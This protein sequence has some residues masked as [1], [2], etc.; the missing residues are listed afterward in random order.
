MA[1]QWENG[2]TRLLQ[3]HSGSL[4]WIHGYLLQGSVLSP[5]EFTLIPFPF[6]SSGNS[7]QQLQ[8]LVYCDQ[9]RSQKTGLVIPNDQKG[10]SSRRAEGERAYREYQKCSVVKY[11]VSNRIS[12]LFNS[13]RKLLVHG[14]HMVSICAFHVRREVSCGGGRIRLSNGARIFGTELH[15]ALLH[16]RTEILL[17]FY[18]CV[19]ILQQLHNQVLTLS[20]EPHLFLYG[21]QNV[22][23]VG[24]DDWLIQ[25]SSGLSNHGSPEIVA[26]SI[27][28]YS[29][30]HRCSRVK[31]LE[32]DDLD[33]NPGAAAYQL[34]D[35]GL[36][37]KFLCSP[38]Y[39]FVKL[40]Q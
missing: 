23:S 39:L 13:F 19:D 12:L 36:I 18:L 15:E 5:R 27:S 1:G 30:R 21:D 29:R 6:V 28:L 10:I 16:S 38:I 32:P 40:G 31:V 20:S 14:D 4:W 3:E 17:L 37:I 22:L 7:F 8:D 26:L 11:W 35:V 34:Y 24:V 9:S 33:S 2:H 25:N